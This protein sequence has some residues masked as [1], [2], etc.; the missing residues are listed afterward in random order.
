MGREVRTESELLKALS[1]LDSIL[2]KSQIQTGKGHPPKEWAGTDSEEEDEADDI[3]ENGT[4]YKGVK[5]SQG[6]DK[7]AKSGLSDDDEDDMEKSD[8]VQ[9]G[10]EVSDFLNHL[11][12]AIT[13][14]TIMCSQHMDNVVKSLHEEQGNLVKAVAHNLEV[15]DDA[16]SKSHE[17]VVRFS[18]GPARA[19]KSLSGH[20]AKSANSG[21]RSLSKE[22]VLPLLIKG[23][24]E[25]RINH[26]EVLK[27]EQ[28]GVQ[29][30]NP[31]ILKSLTA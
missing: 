4:D 2:E 30:L 27:V 28:M 29:A 24:E 3:A 22:E 11:T 8:N 12:K 23:V 7:R 21:H 14:Y 19:P 9:Y 18:E 15:L 10:V 16:I 1:D 25:G 6:K 20:M 13:E 26:L 31:Q 5:K 17:N